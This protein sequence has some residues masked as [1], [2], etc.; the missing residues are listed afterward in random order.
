MSRKRQKKMF[1]TSS[2]QDLNH[3]RQ[4]D[5]ED[6]GAEVVEVFRPFRPEFT[7][8]QKNLLKAIRSRSIV[9]CTG[10]AGT[11]KTMVAMYYACE[12]IKE[13]SIKKI[14]GVRPIVE[15][16]RKMGFLP[17]GEDEKLAPYIRPFESNIKKFL[18]PVK[19][20]AMLKNGD[21]EFRT[22]NTMRG[23]EFQNSLIIL[24][25]AQNITVSEM[26]MFITRLGNG[27]RMVVCGD[28][29]QTDINELSGLVAVQERIEPSKNIAFVKL[30]KED[31]FR[32]PAVREF[33]DQY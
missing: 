3:D 11:G 20:K 15:C 7:P 2:F 21:I 5:Q 8:N 30:S 32:H 10:P 25:E 27:S 6:T 9:F 18:E 23:D 24:D 28:E 19:I 17:G 31:I 33:L 14:I 26:K 22:L 16:G 4:T 13:G 12:A 1:E 29:D